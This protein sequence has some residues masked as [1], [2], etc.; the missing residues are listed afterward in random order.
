MIS[1]PVKLLIKLQSTSDVITNSSSEV[2]L[3]KN[4]TSMDLES[5]RLFIYEYDEKHLFQ[6]DWTEVEKMS[7]EEKLKYNFSSGMGDSI[8][9]E[10]Y[11]D[12]VPTDWKSCAFDEVEDKHNYLSVDIDWNHFAT[13]KWLE[14]HLSAKYIC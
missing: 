12:N 3:C 7:N 8:I 11:S 4:N 9:V 6:G 2:F 5:L 13:I 14:E 1:H 10:L